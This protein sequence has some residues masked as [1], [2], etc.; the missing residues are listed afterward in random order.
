MNMFGKHQPLMPVILAMAP[1]LLWTG[2]AQSANFSGSATI[3]Y[4]INSIDNLSNPGNL[5]GLAITG[6]FELSP[7]PDSY[8]VTSGDGALTNN[9]L[10]LGPIAVGRTFSHRFAISG[11]AN[12]GSLD[13]T[14]FGLFSLN[15][16]NNSSDNYQIGVTLDYQLNALAQGDYADTEVS[17]DYF[18]AEN[19]F[20]GSEYITANLFE[21]TSAKSGTSGLLNFNIAAQGT[22]ALWADVNI[23]GHLQAAPVPLPAGAYLLLT[24]LAGII[25]LANNRRSRG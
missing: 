20:S 23:T 6:G 17:L 22:Q 2:Q 21:N 11:L 1:L 9:N 18:D 7:P 25:S 14:Q 16:D 4:T 5:A 13:T 15:L 24:G 19:A 3:T 12:N 10:G 8:A